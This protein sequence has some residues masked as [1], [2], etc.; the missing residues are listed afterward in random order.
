MSAPT[1]LASRPV[2]WDPCTAI[3]WRYRTAGQITGGFAQVVRAVASVNEILEDVKA[4][5]ARVRHDLERV[6]HAVQSTVNAGQ[7]IGSRH[8]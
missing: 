2:R 8:R 4:I 7:T 3:H 5:S 6:E 1:L